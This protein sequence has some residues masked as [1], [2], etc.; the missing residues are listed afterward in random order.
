M[1]LNFPDTPALNQTFTAN[2]VTWRWTGTYWKSQG[3]GAS[4]YIGDSAP[5]NPAGGTMWFESTT[6]K[7]YVYYKDA[8]GNQWVE[9]GGSSASTALTLGAFTTS[10]LAEGSNLYFTTSRATA[11][12]RSAIT[13]SGAA[14]YDSA[15]GVLAIGGNITSVNGQTG[16]VT[17]NTSN[18]AEDTSLYFTPARARSS[19]TVTGPATY[20]T[21]TGVITVQGNINSV[22]GQANAVTLTTTDIPEGTNQYFTTARARSAISATG[23]VAYDSTTGVISLTTGIPRITSVAVTNSS[24]VVTGATTLTSGSTGY[25][26]LTGTD[27]VSGSQVYVGTTAASSTTFVSSTEVRAALPSQSAGGYLIYLVGTDGATAVS[28]S[29]VTF[30]AGPTTVEYLV[31]GGGGGGAAF[32][33]GGGGGAGGFRNSTASVTTGIAY[34]VTVGAGGPGSSTDGSNA[35]NGIDSIFSTIT[36]SGGGGGGSGSNITLANTRAGSAGG[37]GGGGGTRQSLA[38]GA[39]NTPSTSPSQGNNGG[40]SVPGNTSGEAGGGGGGGAGGIGSN[41]TSVPPGGRG[42]AG[43]IGNQISITGTSTYYAGGGGGGGNTSVAPSFGTGGLGGG[44]DGNA[45]AGTPNTGG[46]GGGTGGTGGAAGGSGVVIIAYP[47]T[48]AAPAS[49]SGGLVYDQPTRT[50]YRVYRFTSGT[51]TITW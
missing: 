26:K 29:G 48:F 36:S 20:D 41:A 42:G 10:N 22:N 34:S 2:S 51:G 9:L 21:A 1:A 25:I 49:I 3:T 7:T 12:A 16:A 14:T 28:V 40:T 47:N 27:F 30:I 11:A 43:G 35:T 5:A 44:G 32:S 33:G 19:I 38:G 50:G 4:L 31:V 18:I 45:T 6:G 24:Y 23:I 39:G 37:S 8:D 17:L 15:T 13:V 46:G